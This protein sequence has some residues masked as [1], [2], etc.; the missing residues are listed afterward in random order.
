M[1]NRKQFAQAIMDILSRAP[2][3]NMLSSAAVNMLIF[4]AATE[5][6][7]GT[8]ITQVIGPA[9]GVFQMEPATC[10]D[11][12]RR[13]PADLQAWLI[14]L[15]DGNDH[16]YALRFHLDYAIAAARVHY[17][18]FKEALPESVDIAGQARYWKKYWNTVAGSGTEEQAVKN[19]NLY[20]ERAL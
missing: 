19:F 4:T 12:E 6:L 2:R 20:L 1:L 9:M 10:R 15:R 7:G 18:L 8:Y 13:A 14:G 11:I 3:P 17:Y 16:G 5:S